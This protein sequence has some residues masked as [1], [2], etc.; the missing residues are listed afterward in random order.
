MFFLILST[1]RSF[2]AVVGVRAMVFVAEH[3]PTRVLIYSQK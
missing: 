2:Y 1:M 3:S